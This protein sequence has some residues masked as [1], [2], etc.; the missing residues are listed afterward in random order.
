MDDKETLVRFKESLKAPFAFI[1]D[2]DAKLTTLYDV[3]MPVLS[4]A[5]RYTFVIDEERKIV[6]VESGKDAI[7]PSGAITS[8]PIH[9]KQGA[10]KVPE[11][12]PAKAPAPA[13]TGPQK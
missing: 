2:T 6:K 5:N 9:K 8:C 10:A 7:D 1:P 11:S 3:K 13:S 4:V 12:S